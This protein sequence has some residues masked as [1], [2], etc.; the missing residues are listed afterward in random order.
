MD[1]SS[2]GRHFGEAIITLMVM[3][4]LTGAAAGVA[5]WLVVPWLISH[6]TIALH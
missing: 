1:G 5:L 6:V 3:C 4:A 2:F